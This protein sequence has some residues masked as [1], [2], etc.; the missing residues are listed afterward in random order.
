MPLKNV[1]AA[2]V[3]AEL[4]RIFADFGTPEEIKSDNGPQFSSHEFEKFC[5]RIGV[6]SVISSPEFPQSNGLAERAAQTVKKTIK[7]MFQ[8]G[9]TL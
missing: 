9:K 5:H 4:D 6:K 7:K 8:D 3:I 2:G 1:N